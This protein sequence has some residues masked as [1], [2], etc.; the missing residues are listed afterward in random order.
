M[1]HGSPSTASR[2]VP[3]SPCPLPFRSLA[4]SPPCSLFFYSL[5]AA[6]C[7]LAASP[8]SP[9]ASKKPGCE[10]VKLWTA[11]N[12]HA[13]NENQGSTKCSPQKHRN[14]E[15]VSIILTH[16]ESVNC[17]KP[18]HSFTDLLFGRKSPLKSRRAPGYSRLNPFIMS[19]LGIQFARS[20][21]RS[22]RKSKN[23]KCGLARAKRPQICASAPEN[24]QKSLN[25]PAWLCRSSGFRQ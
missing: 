9:H 6:P 2:L 22:R 19:N 12:L 10:T 4:P 25:L 21:N 15:T 14:C 11:H 5:L 7:S 16:S 8:P 1:R 20:H 3:S 24:Q 17:G 23:K 18:L 13:I